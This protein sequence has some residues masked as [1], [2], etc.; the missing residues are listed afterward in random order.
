MPATKPLSIKAPQDLRLELEGFLLHQ[1]IFALDI[2]H[3]GLAITIENG[4]VIRLRP[5]VVMGV[6]VSAV[7]RNGVQIGAIT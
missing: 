2:D 6:A 7:Y 4:D 5:L 1:K 3:N